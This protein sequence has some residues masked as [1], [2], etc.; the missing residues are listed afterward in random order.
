MTYFDKVLASVCL[1][2]FIGLLFIGLWPLD[3]SPANEV[4][5]LKD[6]NGLHFHGNGIAPRSSAGGIS[7]TP[8]PLASPHQDLAEKGAVSIEI[9]LRPAVE[10]KN[11]RSRI[12]S[13][14]DD[15]KKETLFIDQ[16]KSYLL[17]FTRVLDCGVQKRYR[18]IGVSKALIR[19]KSQFVT[20]TSGKNG[21]A[22]YLEGKLVKRFPKARLIPASKSISG[23]T[24]LTGNSA[25]AK[26]SWAG[27]LFGL[28][29]YDS[30]LS[31]TQAL[32]HF[33]QWTKSDNSPP[34]IQED[35]IALY[36]FNERSGTWAHNS[37]G[38]S[39][40]L[41]IP[42]RLQFEKKI[43][44]PPDVSQMTKTSFIKDAI[45]N[46][47]GFIPFG[48]FLT[49]WLIRTRQWNQRYAYIVA[50]IL[51]F[52]VSLTIELLQIYLPTRDSSLMD[53]FCNTF[54]AGI[55]AIINS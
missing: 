11:G 54:G 32:H 30:S 6:G 36:A 26:H 47:V 12:L 33:Q 50:I 18:E 48:F 24:L 34:P 1:V 55:G 44:V 16:W 29:V 10:P 41:S 25:D 28:A 4:W 38:A 23:Q 2:I 27:D 42:H 8:N 40:S 53:L 43:L 15:T 21:T 37:L 17:I 49:L 31:E 51:G 3:F 45:I 39:N 22:I 52:L 46:V 35:A 5:W 13:F 9:W 14:S 20:I 7:F 19:G